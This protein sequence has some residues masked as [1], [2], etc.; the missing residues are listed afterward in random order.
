MPSLDVPPENDA[1]H[2]VAGQA[3]R[4][5]AISLFADRALS[6]DKKFKLTDENAP[7]VADICRRLDGI[8]LAIELAASRVKM[9]SPRQLRERLDERFRVLTGGSRD[10]LP[11]QQTLRAM[12]DW[13]HDLL[14][15]RERV[16]F[17][18]LGIFV[19]GFTLEGAVAA[20]SGDD[21]DEIDVFDVLASLVDKSLVLAETD[22]DSLRYR[23]LEST[24]A[25]ALEKMSDAGERDAIASRHLEYLRERFGELWEHMD[26]TG[27][28]GDMTRALVTELDDVRAALDAALQRGEIVAGGALLAATAST[29]LRL[30][31]E[32]EIVAR[33][34]AFLFALGQEESLLRVRLWAALSVSLGA[35]GR[36]NKSAEAAA[37][38]LGIART[39]G[40]GPA[41]AASLDAYSLSLLRQ[42]RT[43]EAEAALTEAEAIP[44]ASPRMR[45]N[46]STR[47]GYLHQRRGAHESAAALFG[48]LHKEHRALGN[49]D[50]ANLTS[51]NLAECEHALGRTERAIAIARESLVSARGS[52]AV[53]LS[54]N[55][56]GY[57]ISI[58]DLAGTV[59]A[60][61]ATVAYSEADPGSA[62]VAMAL[63]HVALAHALGGDPER[64]ATLE[65]YAEATLARLGFL[66]ET[67]EKGS[68][69]RLTALLRERLVSEEI[70]RLAT[71]GAA[72]EPSAAVALALEEK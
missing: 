20:G 57:L 34:E 39:S 72:L 26:R 56:A 15:E 28:T 18:R 52:N 1:E 31:L 67:N 14:D 9:L 25:Y 53:L 36:M 54:T 55:L 59:E 33:C 38:A 27:R 68:F 5:A 51:L 71:A 63:E 41:L 43:D 30:G 10:T 70:E 24:R 58:G 23:L 69:D 45:S 13:S 66:R 60:G 46:L 32:D 21:L 7:M 61:R 29:L 50:D 47:R 11:R 19:D 44:D 6:A 3:I 37:H 2:L 49:T 16:L 12:I 48:R 8:P 17:R 22:G 42:G 62:Y 35:R 4:S 65:G 40:D 64:A